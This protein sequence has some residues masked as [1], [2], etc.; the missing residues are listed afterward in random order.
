MLNAVNKVQIMGQIN[1]YSLEQLQSGNIMHKDANSM[2]YYDL[3]EYLESELENRISKPKNKSVKIISKLI[4]SL[5]AVID[6]SYSINNEVLFTD[7]LYEKTLSLKKMYQENIKKIDEYDII[8]FDNL[9]DKMS[10]IEIKKFNEDKS[11][12]EVVEDITVDSDLQVK[13]KEYKSK[14]K[15]LKNQIKELN[16][17]IN[18]LNKIVNE[19]IKKEEL[20]LLKN[21]LEKLKEKNEE[22][23][24]FINKLNF[25]N[26]KLESDNKKLKIAM[27]EEKK[28]FDVEYSII[29]TQLDSALVDVKKYNEYIN[30]IEIK[31]EIDSL[32][33]DS[34]VESK[35]TISE[36]YSVLHFLYPSIT[37]EDIFNSL[38]RLKANYSISQNAIYEYEKLY[39]IGLNY[40]D[41]YTINSVS[42][43]LDIIVISDLHIN[44]DI[45]SSLYNLN[46]IY[47]YATNNDIRVILNLGDFIDGHFTNYNNKLDQFKYNDELINKVI[48]KLPKDENIINLLLGGNHDR[49]V[50]SQGID[51]INKIANERID[52]ASLNYDHSFLKI[53][54]TTLGLHH[55]NKRYTDDFIKNTSSNNSLVSSYL[56]SYY[57]RKK[58]QKSSIYLDLLGHYHISK[59]STRGS[60][61]TVPSL[62]NDHI[63][64]G[65]WR[66]R[67]FFDSYKNIIEA[68]LIP[69]VIENKVLSASAFNYQKVK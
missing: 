52:Y 48:E 54:N 35:Q 4:Y 6:A 51:V 26:S 27:Q 24:D 49:L 15:E 14:I 69:L 64:N 12:K 50:M 42:D 53:G 45:E 19:S 65:A 7:E 30:D 46:L 29:K 62:N 13:I 17:R 20:E 8:M 3:F 23:N 33:L 66:I 16:N 9:Y 40:F 63:Q 55:V 58:V 57:D 39:G 38:K 44:N 22:L 25:V 31:E 32:V 41:S 43:I 59:F 68:V 11:E 37:K 60:Y 34:I 28:S 2:K 36:I 5:I 21:E 56:E 1:K 61:V 18:S 47:E 10:N 67:F